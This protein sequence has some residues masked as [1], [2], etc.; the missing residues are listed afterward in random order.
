VEFGGVSGT[1]ESIGLFHT[2]VLTGDNRRVYIPNHDVISSKITNYA[3]EPNR[4]V[5]L[6]FNVALGADTTN[7][8]A[9]V[10]EA[11]RRDSRVFT[12]PSP[13]TGLELI[14]P[15]M[16]QYAVRVWCKR[17]DYWDVYFTLNEAIVSSLREAGIELK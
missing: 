17:G 9:A 12:D 5:D 7:V 15:G 10:A 6:T 11:I 13:F 4:R 1:V 8:K 14:K 16:L 3:Q 2:R